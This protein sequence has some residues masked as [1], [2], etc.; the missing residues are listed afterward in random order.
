MYDARKCLKNQ[1]HSISG[2]NNGLQVRVLPGSPLTCKDLAHFLGSCLSPYC[3]DFC[4]DSYLKSL[5]LVSRQD[6]LKRCPKWPDGKLWRRKSN[7]RKAG[8][9]RA[10]IPRLRGQVAGNRKW[11]HARNGRLDR[12]CS[13]MERVCEEASGSYRH[14]RNTITETWTE[15][16]RNLKGLGMPFGEIAANWVIRL[17]KER[18]L[19]QHLSA[20]GRQRGNIGWN[21]LRRELCDSHSTWTITGRTRDSPKPLGSLR[22]SSRQPAATNLT[23]NHHGENCAIGWPGWLPF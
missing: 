12:L 23:K 6:S 21:W 11:H 5:S 8:I 1:L 19:T 18:A 22:K 17:P 3:G 7:P 16:K 2:F 20:F 14:G 10:A 4:G 15:A 13:Q 9:T